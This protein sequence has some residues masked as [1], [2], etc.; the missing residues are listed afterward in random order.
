M[1]SDATLEHRWLRIYVVV[2]VVVVVAVVVVVLVIVLVLALMPML[3]LMLMRM[4]MLMLMLKISIGTDKNRIGASVIECSPRFFSVGV[5]ALL[6]F[7]YNIQVFL[8][9]FGVG[10]LN[11]DHKTY[12]NNNN[13]NNFE[14]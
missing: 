8:G 5:G 9:G 1:I 3:M 13:N 2:V 4:L 12:H 7:R 6:G 11:V 14:K 10:I